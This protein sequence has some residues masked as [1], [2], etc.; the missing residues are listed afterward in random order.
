MIRRM[1]GASI[2][3]L[4]LFSS[5]AMAGLEPQALI[6]EVAQKTIDRLNAEQELI[7]KEPERLY[8]LINEFVLPHF[9]FERMSK[10]VLGKHWRR[11]SKQ[12]QQRFIEEFRTL[13]VRTYASSLSDYAQQTIIYLPFHG[14][15]NS[16]EVMVKSEVEQPG[17]FGIPINYRLYKVNSDWKVYDVTIDD[18][19]LVSN[20]RTSF[21]REINIKGIDGL[22]RE[23]AEKNQKSM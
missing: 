4:A 2:I 1:L 7:K 15:L 12:E 8:S 13:L 23:M 19:S 11:A 17:S 18:I 21:S 5:N 9:D 16:G 20:Y 10:W 14:D 3:V 6:Q 22:I